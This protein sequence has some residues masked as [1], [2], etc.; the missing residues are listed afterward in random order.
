MPPPH[1]SPLISM[2]LG[3]FIAV[4][5]HMCPMCLF[6]GGAVSGHVS[7]CLCLSTCSIP[8]NLLFVFPWVHTHFS[9]FLFP[10]LS[11]VSH[12]WCHQAYSLSTPTVKVAFCHP[13]DGMSL[14]LSCEDHP[15]LGD[16]LSS[17]VPQHL[18]SHALGSHLLFFWV[19]DMCPA[20]GCACSTPPSH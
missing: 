19:S 6:R 17:V 2:T 10:F 3:V 14:L 11:P 18:S 16:K 13:S 20:Q 4:H 15:S 5:A 8:P 12:F 1:S 9:H 7:L